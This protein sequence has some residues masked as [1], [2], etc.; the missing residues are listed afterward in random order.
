MSAVDIDYNLHLTNMV[1]SQFVEVCFALDRRR[2]RHVGHEPKAFLVT[3]IFNPE[4]ASASI[5]RD[6]ELLH[7]HHQF[8]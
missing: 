1:K 8:S 6:L 3:R 2:R 7:L 5:R 4:A